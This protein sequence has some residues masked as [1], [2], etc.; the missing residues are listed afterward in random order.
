MDFSNDNQGSDLVV[1]TVLS[2]DKWLTMPDS[3]WRNWVK[4]SETK[5]N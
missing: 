1:M 5:T 4:P 3:A 2:Q